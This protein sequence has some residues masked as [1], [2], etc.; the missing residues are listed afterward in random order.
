LSEVMRGEHP[1]RRFHDEITRD[2]PIRL[3]LQDCVIAWHAFRKARAR[4]IGARI[5]LER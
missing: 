3:S 4:G 5:D 2:S 1:G